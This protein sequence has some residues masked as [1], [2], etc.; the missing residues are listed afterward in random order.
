[1]AADAER[2]A[3]RLFEAVLGFGDVYMVYVGDRLGLYRAL[4][5]H[6]A[7]TAP[8]LAKATGTDPRYV[9]E[10]LEQQAVT[11]ILHV[12][13][14]Q[15]P[16]ERRYSISDGHAEVL[17][18]RDSL[19]FMAPFLRMMVGMTRP[20]PSVLEAFRNGGGVAYADFDADFVEG[21]GD[22]NRVQ[23]VNLLGQS[24]LPALPDVDERLRADPPA[25]VADVACGVGWS[26]ISIARAYP[27]VRVEG[28]DLDEE[29][30]RLARENLE[31]QG[32]GDRVGFEVRDAA[33]LAGEGYD[34][35]TVFE[36]VHDLSRP[37]EVLRA[38]R[39]A[40]GDGGRVLI[41][42]Q[43]AAESFAAPGDELERMLYVWSVMHCL[44]VGMAEQPSAGT[45]AAMRPDTLRAY[46]EEAG[47][48]EVEVLPIDNDFWRFY[49]L[50]P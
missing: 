8:E 40:L 47:F 20:L 15:A 3:E 9:R 14:E 4:A 46:A 18:E 12:D 48:S 32:L 17:L 25:R 43:R 5:D 37:V 44:P 10:W 35:I 33:E 7:A 6:G 36:A 28:F 26:T 29:S 19:N 31:T 50:A 41:A 30:I 49:L 45:G 24:W 16:D 38:L 13:G 11:G 27:K 39:E 1:M 21:Q 22:A 34:L 2:L 23:F 42:D